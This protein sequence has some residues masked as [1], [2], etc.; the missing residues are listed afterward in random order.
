[1][2]ISEGQFQIIW[3][4]IKHWL[5]V[6]KLSPAYLVYLPDYPLNYIKR[7]MITESEWLT[8][9]FIHYCFE[10]FGLMSAR[11]RGIE[12]TADILSDEEIIA[13]L[14]APLR[15]TKKQFEFDI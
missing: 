11:Q 3:Q 6:K 2:G 8:S 9:D 13:A 15:E 5:R 14:T 1:M 4:S 10:Q 7:G 12:D